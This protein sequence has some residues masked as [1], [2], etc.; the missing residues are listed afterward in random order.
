MQD[1]IIAVL[2]A[3]CLIVFSNI[4]LKS[5]HFASANKPL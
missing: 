2:E 3:S 5:V 1:M 4:S